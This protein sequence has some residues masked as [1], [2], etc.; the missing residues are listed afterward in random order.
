MRTILAFAILSSIVPLFGSSYYTARLDDPRAIYLTQETFPVKGDGIADDSA[1]L[2]QAINT[3]QE[4]TNQGILFVPSGRYRLTKTIYVW[5]GIRLIGFG[6]TRPAF[7]LA[8]NT[9]RFQQGPAYM[10]FFAGARPNA[11]NPPPDAN[12]GTFYSAISNI[13]IE[14]QEGNPGAVG[15]RARYAQHCFLAHMDFHIGSGLAGIHDGGNVA[16]DLHFYGGQY[17]IWTRKPSPGWQFTLIDVSFEGQREAAIREHEAGLTLI[18]P[19]FKNVPTAISI[20]PQ[21]SEELWIKDG[22]MEDITGPAVIISNENS[23]RTEINMENVVCR[24]VPVFATYRESGKRVAAPA[25]L[26]AVKTFSHGLQYQDISSIPAIHDVY[27][28]TVLTALPAPAKSDILDLPPIDT[29]VNIRSLGAKGDGTTDDTDTLRNAIA[30]HRTIYLPSGQYRVTDTITLRPDT[31]LIGLHPSVTRIL[32]ADSTP[33]FE[34]VGPPK[35]LLETP[36]GG[37]NIVTGIGLYTNGIN[38]RAVAAK[39]MAGTDSMMNDVRFLGG[40]GTIDP[41]ATAEEARKVRRQIYN[42]NHTG[43]SNPNRRW[44]SQYPSLWITGGGTFVGIWT[45]STFAQAGLYISNTS[46]GGRIYELSSEH[47]VRNEVVLDHASN[48]QIYALQTEEERGEGG[49]ALPLDIR[50]SSNITFANLHMYRVVSSYQPFKYAAS[51]ANSS[52]IRFR[53]LHCYS[54]SKVSFDSAI[55]DQTHGIELRQREFSWLTIS[56]APP[57]VRPSRPSALLAEGAQVQKLAGNFFNI[58]GGA[59]DPAGNV[60]FADAKWQ[61]IYCWSAA[62]RQ[63][64]KVRDNALDPVQLFFD[65]AG[66]LMVVSYAGEGTVYAFRPGIADDGI[67]LLKAVPAASRPGMTPVLPVDYWRNENDF[68]ETIPVKQPYH[69]ISPDRTTF[70]PTAKDFV[71]GE[72]YYGSK[73]NS[74]LRAFGFAPAVP[75]QPYYVTDEDEEKTY[76]ATIG[77]DGT[78][79]NLKLFAERGGESVAWDEQGNVYLAAGQVYVYNPAGELIDTI[80]I[81]ERPAQLLFGGRDGKTL[82]VLARS[83][84]YA[85]QTRYQGH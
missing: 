35:P 37:T 43:D 30:R 66:N 40:H 75:G 76:S 60:Y 17:A 51:I 33:G 44:D 1:G 24:K 29:W 22:R 70:L 72:L 5:P 25:E 56:G 81:P 41:N 73:L 23:A 71:T 4:K 42:D 45:P 36:K 19:Q 46:T 74:T 59:V 57:E 47:H 34:G 48:W 49:F 62:T 32:L 67:T 55:Y 31:V 68:L 63:L 54:D 82:F 64:S 80:D 85:I 21:Y 50:D 2:Q 83:S 79:S 78:I 14:I 12:P 27:E 61:T 39:W 3:V 11:E 38:P 69:Y 6:R 65:K 15:I 26:Y 18:R 20:D 10:V 77:D 52:N 9:P 58:S 84:L 53:N 28:T 8:A 13:D 7:V 16:E